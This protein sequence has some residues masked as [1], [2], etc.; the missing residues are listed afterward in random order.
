M[1]CT[2]PEAAGGPTLTHRRR[3]TGTRPNAASET[4]ASD[5]RDS[6]R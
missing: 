5:R 6:R 2:L 3:S 4:A 1:M